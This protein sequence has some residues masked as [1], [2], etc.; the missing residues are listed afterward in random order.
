MT[1]DP[2]ARQVASRLRPV[3]RRMALLALALVLAAGV[4]AIVVHTP[5][6]RR[7]VLRYATA[8]VQ[9][10]YG[11]RLEAAGLDYNLASLTIGLAQVRISVDRSSDVP[12]FEADY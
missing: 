7:L 5:A 4:I 6:F 2:E 9:R 10:R 12:F 11:I 8:E 1:D 3:V